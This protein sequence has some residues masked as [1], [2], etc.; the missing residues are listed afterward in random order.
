MRL[1][2]E[3]PDEL[4][5]AA[6][7]RVPGGDPAVVADPTMGPQIAGAIVNIALDRIAAGASTANT[8]LD[9]AALKAAVEA[10]L[11]EIAGSEPE[12]ELPPDPRGEPVAFRTMARDEFLPVGDERVAPASFLIERGLRLINGAMTADPD[13][14]IAAADR[15]LGMNE[16]YIEVVVGAAE[17]RFTV[18]ARVDGELVAFTFH[19]G[20]AIIA[21][22]IAAD[23]TPVRDSGRR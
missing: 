9:A 7:A 21:G 8:P 5:R 23:P 10:E 14:R 13:A 3:I 6:I 18:E 11:I 20:G 12:R 15:L 16:R 19:P 4:L 1:T 2:L 22:S 17:R